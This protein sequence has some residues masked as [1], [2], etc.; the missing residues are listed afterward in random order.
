M[1]G[2]AHRRVR[3]RDQAGQRGRLRP[4]RRK[5]QDAVGLRVRLLKAGRIALLTPLTTRLHHQVRLRCKYDC[6]R[7]VPCAAHS[8]VFSM[9]VP[10]VLGPVAP[11]G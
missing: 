8:C 4:A 10:A 6:A 3:C 7:N 1:T 11:A 5:P 2:V 9:H